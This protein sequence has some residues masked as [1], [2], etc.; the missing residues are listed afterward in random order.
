VRWIEDL[1][2]VAKLLDWFISHSES[3]AMGPYLAVGRGYR[4]LLAIR[5]GDA[6]GGVEGLQRALAELHSARYELLTV[7]FNISLVQGL[8][9]IGRSAEATT[10]IE[11]TIRMVETSGELSYMPELLRVKGSTLFL[12]PQHN[13]DDAEGN[14]VRSLEL[15]REQGSRAWEL[16]TATDL[17]ALWAG[18][19]RAADA[20][21]LLRP[22]YEQFTEGSGTA[23]LETAKNLLAKLG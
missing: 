7:I 18:Q 14:L 8:A 13:S 4:G 5:R 17:A 1:E 15:S 11:E 2:T 6:K 23:D 9:A 22:L 10:L 16:R 3:H 19:G 21:A 20:R 12:D